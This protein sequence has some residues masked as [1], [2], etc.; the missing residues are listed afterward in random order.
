MTIPESEI[1]ADRELLAEF[2]IADLTRTI[3][4][5][6]KVP[7]LIRSPQLE[8]QMRFLYAARR[9]LEGLDDD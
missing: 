2:M 5:K 8:S 7:E 1:L 3:K 6:R 4:R 9:L